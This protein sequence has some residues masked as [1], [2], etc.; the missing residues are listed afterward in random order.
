MLPAKLIEEH[1]VQ[2]GHVFL[3]AIQRGERRCLVPEWQDEESPAAFLHT[4]LQR[5]SGRSVEQAGN[6]LL[7]LRSGQWLGQHVVE[8]GRQ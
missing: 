2:G 1:A 8:S 7:Q 5:L 3:V 6:G 4:Q